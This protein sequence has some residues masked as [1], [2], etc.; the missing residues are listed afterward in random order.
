MKL[1]ISRYCMYIVPE[2][3]Q[4]VVYLEEV[5]G[6]EKDGSEA[7]VVRT[8]SML[9]VG[10]TSTIQVLKKPPYQAPEDPPND[11]HP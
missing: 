11:L 10:S 3:E 7:R 9:P 2:T 1:N 6:L 5:L 4:D 8:Y